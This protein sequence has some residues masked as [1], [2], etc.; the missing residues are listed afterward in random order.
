MLNSMWCITA[1]WDNY[2]QNCMMYDMNACDAPLAIN[3]MHNCCFGD[4]LSSLHL[5]VCS[6]L[7]HSLTY[8]TYIIYTCARG[9]LLRMSCPSSKG[10]VFV[11][12]SKCG[13]SLWF[14]NGTLKASI[15]FIKQIVSLIHIKDTEN[16]SNGISHEKSWGAAHYVGLTILLLYKSETTMLPF[17]VGQQVDFIVTMVIH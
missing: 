2:P 11:Q 14:W 3:V 5:T 10:V 9:P 15:A 1:A 7:T 17:E 8:N 16:E 12:V 6:S 13:C 4:G